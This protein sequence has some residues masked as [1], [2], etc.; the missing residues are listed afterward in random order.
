MPC[1]IA[2]VVLTPLVI[3]L[4]RRIGAVEGGGYRKIHLDTTPLLG[5]LAIFPKTVC[6]ARD[7]ERSGVEH[8]H[9]HFVNHPA[10]AAFVIHRLTD[11]PYSFT[12]HGADLQV[13][14]HMLRE[15]VAESA[16]A[17]AISE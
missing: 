17:V 5:G 12:A 6:M 16:F 1:L 4:A 3:R 11:I 13:D 14:Q 2:T 9:A 7:M 10:A 15:K 8:I